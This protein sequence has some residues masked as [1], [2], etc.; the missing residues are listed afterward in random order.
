MAARIWIGIREHVEH[1]RRLAVVF[2]IPL[3]LKIVTELYQ[4]EMSPSQ[5][6]KEFGGGSRSRVNQNFERLVE[7]DWLREVRC[8]GPGGHRRGGTERFYRATELAFCDQETWAAL[9]YSIRVAFSWNAF[10][11]IARRL[12]E[13]M[14]ARTFEA[15]AGR[16]LTATR[17]S[18]DEFGWKRVITAVAAEFV[19]QFDEQEDA[20][21]RTVHEGGPSI[22]AGSILMAFESPA[23]AGL[24]LGPSLVETKESMSPL[25]P[26]AAM[27]F[28]DQICMQIIEDANWE[29][30]SVPS[31]H[32]RYAHEFDVNIEGI[33]SRFKRLTKAG[34]LTE[35]SQRTG[36]A[37]RGGHERF[38]R[39]TRPAMFDDQ[40][41]PLAEVPDEIRESSGWK[42]FERLSRWIREAMAAGTFDGRPD[43][44]LAWSILHLDLRGWEKV[45]ASVEELLAFV[46]D[47]QV[48]AKARMEE[49]GER[50]IVATV[51]LGAFES[52]PDSDRE[53]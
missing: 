50:P 12:R 41:G 39:A 37:R 43:R 14:E 2:A 33:R 53:L 9:P 47:E 23:E 48:L 22:R 25:P 10:I 3:R 38:Y 6:H 29:D 49:T 46:L 5:F 34:W 13:A 42:T 17:L 16:H 21:C 11:T 18:L 4:R 8:E 1:L 31:F 30:V 26:R 44:C 52:S 7:W 28:K 19:A 35:V 15:R 24:R 27:V 36:G 45:V 51:A 20:R 40:N 32:A